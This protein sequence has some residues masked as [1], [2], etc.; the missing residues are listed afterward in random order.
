MR[1]ILMI[2]CLGILLA[3]VCSSCKP[4]EKNYKAA[5]EAAQK[6]RMKDASDPDILIPQ[7]GLINDDTPGI[8]TI[9]SVKTYVRYEPLKLIEGKQPLK[10][11]NVAIASFKMTANAKASYEELLANYPDAVLLQSAKDVYYVCIISTSDK[12]Q[13]VKALRDFHNSVKGVYLGIPEQQPILE[14]ASNVKD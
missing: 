14:V 8:E 1:K 4:T 9:D 12:S 7:G 5:Y 13:A 6:K 3:G 10:R 11:F 2:T